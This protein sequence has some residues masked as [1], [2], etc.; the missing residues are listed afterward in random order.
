[1][2][3]CECQSWGPAQHQC[4][5]GWSL[6]L[7]DRGESLLGSTMG[8]PCLGLTS[9]PEELLHIAPLLFSPRLNYSFA[10]LQPCVRLA[11]GPAETDPNPELWADVLA[12][13]FL[14]PSPQRCLMLLP[15]AALDC[16]PICPASWL[17]VVGQALPCQP[18]CGARTATSCLPSGSRLPSQKKK[19]QKKK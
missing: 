17:W 1:V 19:V 14:S 8:R 15:G 13:P 16:T 7:D 4:N 12:W 11:M 18:P 5:R 3:N 10:G 2:R 9:D 6:S